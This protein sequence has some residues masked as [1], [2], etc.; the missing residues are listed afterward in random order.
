MNFYRKPHDIDERLPRHMIWHRVA[1]ELLGCPAASVPLHDYICWP[2]PWDPAVVRALLARVEEVTG[3]RWADAIGAQ[4]HF[5]DESL[6]GVFMDRG[7][8][9]NSNASERMY[10]HH[11]SDETPLDER[12]LIAFLSAVQPD[13][14]SFLPLG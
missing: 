5:S 2:C 11:H 7:A 1:R 4:R 6:Y 9:A 10:C 14:T 13:A 3:K 12:G 8:S